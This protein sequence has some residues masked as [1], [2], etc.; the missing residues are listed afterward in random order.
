MFNERE[1]EF[2]HKITCGGDPLQSPHGGYSNRQSKQMI[3]WITNGNY[4][5]NIMQSGLLY[6]VS[7]VRRCSRNVWSCP[8]SEDYQ[9]SLIKIVFWKGIIVVKVKIIVHKLYWSLREYI[10]HNYFFDRSVIHEVVGVFSVMLFFGAFHLIVSTGDKVNVTI[11]LWIISCTVC[12]R[13][14]LRIRLYFAF[15]RCAILLLISIS[16]RLC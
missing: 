5:M 3:L 12:C 4:A 9:F 6:R 14:S 10:R 15:H 1:W 13:L 7:F 11:I 16:V 8:Q 2:L